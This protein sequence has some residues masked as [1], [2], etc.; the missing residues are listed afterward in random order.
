MY[1]TLRHRLRAYVHQT[2]AREVIIGEVK[3]A[4]VERGENVLRPRNKQPNDGTPLARDGVKY[5][6]RARALEKYRAAAHEQRAEPVHFCAGVV[7]RRNAE[8]NVIMRLR[9]VRMLDA[10]GVHKRAVLVQNGLGEARRA[11]RKV[12][13]G[14]VILTETAGLKARG[15]VGGH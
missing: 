3:L 2:P 8:E 10:A 12:N 4:R 1:Q 7:E 6:R 5:E 11:G 15:A 13:R 9:V 14:V